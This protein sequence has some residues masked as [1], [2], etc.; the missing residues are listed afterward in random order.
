M[1]DTYE[2]ARII[3]RN[4]NSNVGEL[5]ITIHFASLIITVMISDLQYIS[6]HHNTRMDS[7][8]QWQRLF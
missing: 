6:E 3:V 1:Y 4:L 8:V 5:L 7:E 2:D